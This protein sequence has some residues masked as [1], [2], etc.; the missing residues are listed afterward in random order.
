MLS[1][2]LTNKCS[3]LQSSLVAGLMSLTVSANAQDSQDLQ[4]H[5]FIAQGIIE[6]SDSDFVN[7]DGDL[8]SALTEL[9]VNFSYQLAD[10]LR[11]AGQAV[12]IDGGNRYADG[13]RIDYALLDWTAYQT[14][15]SKLNIYFGRY[16]NYHWLYSSTRDIPHTRPTIVL[17]Q[18][19]YFDGFR[20]I[21][22]GGD[23]VAM[24][25]KHNSGLGDID[26][27]LSYGTSDISDKQTEI[28][29]SEFATGKMTHDTDYQASAYWQPIDSQWRFG[30]V[31]LDSEFGYD[32]SE[33]DTFYDAKIILQR[34]MLNALF[35]GERW[36]F[37][38]EVNQERFALDGFYAPSAHLDRKGQGIYM[39]VR[40]R[41][42]EQIRLLARQ[43]FFYADKDD[44][45]GDNLASSFGL[46]KYFGYQHDTTIGA[47]VDLASN[48][49]LQAEFHWYQGTARLTPVVVPNPVINNSEYWQMWAL[50]LMYWF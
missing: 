31:G 28:I 27:N 49:R 38:T 2:L 47:S 39:Q 43:E 45:D 42:N 46:P 50:Q 10:N 30:I 21:A 41:L 1:K 22:V 19:I 13:A 44:K 7:D 36:E 25:Y 37:S 17:P 3:V 26:I 23:G 9:G 14:L 16:K 34:F 4:I 12:Y 20:D 11:L 24:S 40:Y 29:L 5:G 32:Q 15:E 48:L 6:A 33:N 35:E 18:S 8:S